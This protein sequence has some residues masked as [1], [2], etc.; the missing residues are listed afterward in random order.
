MFMHVNV[1]QSALRA[2][3][4]VKQTARRAGVCVWVWVYRR[5]RCHGAH[6]TAQCAQC[7]LKAPQPLAH[8]WF[9]QPR[10]GRQR[11]KVC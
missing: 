3:L 5:A 11:W 9:N 4:R 10:E 7:I 6:L 8:E 2:L 1:S